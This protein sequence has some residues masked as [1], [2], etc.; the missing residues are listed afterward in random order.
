M[1]AVGV[2]SSESAFARDAGCW[3]LSEKSKEK[4][5]NDLATAYAS[6]PS[7][8]WRPREFQ[9][10]PSNVIRLRNPAR[11]RAEPVPLSSS[12]TEAMHHQ[13]ARCRRAGFRAACC[14]IWRSFTI[15]VQA[16]A[17]TEATSGPRE[18]SFHM[19]VGPALT[20]APTQASQT[21]CIDES[22]IFQIDTGGSL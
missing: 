20:S 9:N 3:L 15:H 10:P 14:P 22:H 17:S 7:T 6:R 13:S 11:P 21:A 1:R 4:S 18:Y 19:D 16:V 12:T 5:E 8:L 2:P